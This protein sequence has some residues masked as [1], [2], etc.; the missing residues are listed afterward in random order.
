MRAVPALV[1]LVAL[2]AF[3]PALPGITEAIDDAA[4]WAREGSTVHGEDSGTAA[5]H[6]HEAPGAEH[7]CSGLQHICRCCPTAHVLPVKLAQ[8]SGAVS[9]EPSPRAWP[10]RSVLGAD[11]RVPPLRPP[12]A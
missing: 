10:V 9:S 2:L 1:R 6:G 8:V 4:H 5:T 12:I 3:L 7:G 11:D